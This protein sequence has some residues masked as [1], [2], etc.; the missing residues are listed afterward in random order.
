MPESVQNI[1]A[2]YQDIES[3]FPETLKG[4]ALPYFI[5]W[6]LENVEMVE[7]TAYSDD[8]AYTIFETMNDRGLSLSPTDM[9]KGYLLAN[10]DGAEEKAH[11]ND[12]WKAQMLALAEFGKEEEADFFK[13][14]LRAKY[15]DTIRERKKGALNEDFERIGTT[16]HKWVRDRK[17]RLGLEH[18]Q[19][20]VVFVEQRL[21]RFSRYYQRVRQAAMNYDPGLAY[22]YY[23]GYSNFTLQYP[24][25]LAPICDTDD[26]DTAMRKIRL[27][28][29]YLDIFIARRIWN[30]RTL[31]YSSLVYGMF[32][33]LKEIRDKSVPELVDLLTARVQDMQET[34]ATNNGFRLHQQNRW[35]VHYLLARITR[36]VEKQSGQ[37]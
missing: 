2:R 18:S 15:A 3:E 19:D 36:H 1:Y 20:F 6:L 26:P 11:A 17:A 10:I 8:D 7:I 16:F 13:A 23:N 33:L 21:A 24:L 27:V 37:G 35:Q 9:L 14:W 34:F 30:F 32:L 22:V 12:V 25:V 31:S 5:D 29:G 4:P 28:A